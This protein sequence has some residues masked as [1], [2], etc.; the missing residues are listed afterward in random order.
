M[1][2]CYKLNKNQTFSHFEESNCLEF[3]N[4]HDPIKSVLA[5]EI[6]QIYFSKNINLPKKI[7][8]LFKKLPFNVKSNKYLL[9]D[10]LEI[11]SVIISELDFATL[12]KISQP[13]SINGFIFKDIGNN[14]SEEEIYFGTKEWFGRRYFPNKLATSNTAKPHINQVI[15]ETKSDDIEHLPR[16]ILISFPFEEFNKELIKYSK[17]GYSAE[18]SSLSV[19]FYD[20][21][22][23]KEFLYS[24]ILTKI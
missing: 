23:R 22:M 5:F 19:V 16:Q 11:N 21:L 18:N 13:K 1:I 3:I 2:S 12:G 10:D 4:R 14:S 17:L 24:V 15:S 6:N 9:I 7:S 20:T 8:E